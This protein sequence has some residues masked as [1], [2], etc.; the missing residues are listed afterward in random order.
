MS[1]VQI[2]G[3]VPEAWN[4]QSNCRAAFIG[5]MQSSLCA[6]T[7]SFPCVSWVGSGHRS[8]DTR[9]FPRERVGSGHETNTDQEGQEGAVL[10]C[11]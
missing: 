1:Q 7:Q 3:L 2:L 10:K 11:E 9:L 4:S 6:Q 8:S 5:I